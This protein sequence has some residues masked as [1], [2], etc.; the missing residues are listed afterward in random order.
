MDTDNAQTKKVTY[1]VSYSGSIVYF[2]FFYNLDTISPILQ[3]KYL[4]PKTNIGRW[5]P[6][7]MSCAPEE[8]KISMHDIT[9]KQ[10]LDT[11]STQ[12]WIH[13]HLE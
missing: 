9:G 10:L 13:R 11:L 8:Q 12:S 6:W 4:R 2:W 7:D 5:E 3:S 1:S